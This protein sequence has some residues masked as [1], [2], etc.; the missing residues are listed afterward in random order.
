M[1][2]PLPPPK[3]KRKPRSA[4]SATS[5]RDCTP[6]ASGHKQ[7][8]G[9]TLNPLAL[10]GTSEAKKPATEQPGP[11]TSP[12]PSRSARLANILGKAQGRG[13]RLYVKDPVE[14][15]A[16]GDVEMVVM[17]RP[18]EENSAPVV[19]EPELAVEE[20]SM[21]NRMCGVFVVL[22]ASIVCGATIVSTAG[23][24]GGE[25][26]GGDNQPRD[27]LGDMN[28]VRLRVAPYVACLSFSAF[29][30]IAIMFRPAQSTTASVTHRGV[31]SKVALLLV[32]TVAIAAASIGYPQGL[33]PVNC[34]CGVCEGIGKEEH[35]SD[36]QN[37]AN[38]SV[39]AERE[40]PLA[41]IR[42]AVTGNESNARTGSQRNC[43]A[44]ND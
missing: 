18:S 33:C 15:A 32:C 26:D 30:V 16:G 40:R 28:C 9:S 36:E 13:A 14:G 38:M 23:A 22:A 11:T 43:S 24:G 37:A 41:V 31:F 25:P 20:H 1:S 39:C 8:G 29:F 10:E 17:A 12:Q 34:A 27:Q 2:S 21:R 7:V 5:A 4:T 19:V 42:D 44:G 6:S 35:V 3:K